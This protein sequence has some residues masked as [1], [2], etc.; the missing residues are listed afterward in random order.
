MDAHRLQGSKSDFGT[1]KLQPYI[2]LFHGL[3]AQ[4][5]LNL[6][7]NAISTRRALGALHL[8]GLVIHGPTC[9]AIC[10]SS[11]LQSF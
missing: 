2:R 1:G 9:F 5:Q 7:N 11:P 8:S 6:L 4:P 10:I 3:M